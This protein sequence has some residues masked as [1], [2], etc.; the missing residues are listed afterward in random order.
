M[1]CETLNPDAIAHMCLVH[2]QNG[3]NVMTLPYSFIV[4]TVA[5]TAPRRPRWSLPANFTPFLLPTRYQ[6]MCGDSYCMSR[7]FD[8]AQYNQYEWTD[9]PVYEHLIN[10]TYEWGMSNN[11]TITRT[12]NESVS[13][14]MVGASH[15]LSLARH[16]RELNLSHV[17]FRHVFSQYPA[18]FDV[19]DLV[20][21]TYAVVGYGQWP[22]SAWMQGQ[23][24]TGTKYESEM[25]KVFEITRTYKPRTQV[26]MRSMNLN[27]LGVMYTSCPAKEYRHPPLVMMYNNLLSKLS[28]EYNIPYIDTF[29]IQGPLWDGSLDWSHPSDKVAT[30]EVEY[31][32]YSVLSYSHKYQIVPILDL[33][34]APPLTRRPQHGNDNDS[35]TM[36]VLKRGEI[37]PYPNKQTMD[38]VGV[39]WGITTEIN[40]KDMANYK[41]GTVLPEV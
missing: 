32:M 36:Y 21:C 10:R 31:I 7:E 5:R 40:A 2:P 26:F 33:T 27:G 37:R 29:H 24:Y 30:A 16:G 18:Q 9:K 14:C 11:P 3:K 38:R 20:N 41:F 28:A 35:E 34:V 12:G 23:P 6:Q 19:L 25:R 13:I 4:S 17:S 22:L 1:Y 39:E 15:A 8:V